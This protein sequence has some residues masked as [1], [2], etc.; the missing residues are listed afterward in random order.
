M[1]LYLRY[2]ADIWVEVDTDGEDVVNVVVDELTMAT[3]VDVIDDGGAVA[4][5]ERGAR[6]RRIADSRCWPS[7]DYGSR[8]V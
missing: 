2:Q 3:P 1:T 5:A 6:A 7:W 8:P 4:A